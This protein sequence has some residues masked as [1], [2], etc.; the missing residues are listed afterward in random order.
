MKVRNDHSF[1]AFMAFSLEDYV[2]RYQQPLEEGLSLAVYNGDDPIF[3]HQG[4]W[5]HPLFAL[6]EFLLTYEG[7]RIFC[8]FTTAPPEKPLRFFKRGLECE[9]PTSI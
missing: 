1:F 6:E 5:L 2:T 8:P 4:H 9:E 7:P 3:T